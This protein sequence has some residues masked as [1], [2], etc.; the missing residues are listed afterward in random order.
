M[1]KIHTMNIRGDKFLY[2]WKDTNY[3]KRKV[4][5]LKKWLKQLKHL[6]IILIIL[7]IFYTLI[8]LIYNF[9]VIPQT[10]ANES[11]QDK[12][13]QERLQVCQK[14][15]KESWIVKNQIEL[16]SLVINCAIRMHGVYIVESRTWKSEVRKNNF[17]WIKRTINWYYGFNSFASWYDCRLYFARKYAEFH[18]KK[19]PRTFIYWFWIDNQWQYGWSTTD[20]ESYTNTLTKIENNKELRRDYEYLYLTK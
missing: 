4:A 6:W 17:L 16:H 14:A 15:I 7:C 9:N 12:I 8:S 11:I 18:Y 2:I 3:K 10:N 19:D 20:Q 1:K 5:K 13:R